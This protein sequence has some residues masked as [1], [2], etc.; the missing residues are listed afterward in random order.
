M[1]ISPKVLSLYKFF[2]DDVTTKIN[3][4]RALIPSFRI[5]FFLLDF[6]HVTFGTALY[7]F[8]FFSLS[9]RMV[10]VK[11]HFGVIQY[12]PLFGC[13]GDAFLCGD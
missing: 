1:A 5:V 13:E 9:F 8:F 3:G 12:G 4:L 10:D 2:S 6:S 11:G 7:Y